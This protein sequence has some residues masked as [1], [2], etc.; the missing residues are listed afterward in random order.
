MLALLILSTEDW[1]WSFWFN[2]SVETSSKQLWWWWWW[3]W[4]WRWWILF[5]V[6]LISEGLLALSPAGTIVRDAHHSESL[7]RHKLDWTCAEPEFRLFR[8][9]LCSSFITFSKR[10]VEKTIRLIN[11]ELHHNLWSFKFLK[12]NINIPQESAH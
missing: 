12:N 6:W 10:E 11:L 2:E 4:C 1:C 8:M 7:T 3:W 5:V 9:K